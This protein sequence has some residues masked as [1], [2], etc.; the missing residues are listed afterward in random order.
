MFLTTTKTKVKTS[1]TLLFYQVY[2]QPRNLPLAGNAI[3]DTKFR[4]RKFQKNSTFSRY[5]SAAL[6][7]QTLVGFSVNTL[8]IGNKNIISKIQESIHTNQVKCMVREMISLGS[9]YYETGWRSTTTCML[10]D[11]FVSSSVFI[12]EGQSNLKNFKISKHLQ[13]V[14]SKR[15]SCELNK[16]NLQENEHSGSPLGLCRHS[17]YSSGFLVYVPGL[18]WNCSLVSQQLFQVIRA[19]VNNTMTF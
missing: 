8:C 6:F 18:L 16:C 4:H 19:C 15:S 14:K 12:Q 11:F 1:L 2:N 3:T 10:P 7:T 13:K 9:Q 17:L 5:N